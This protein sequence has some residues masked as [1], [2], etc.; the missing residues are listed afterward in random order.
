MPCSNC[1]RP[2]SR[3]VRPK[4]CDRGSC[5][6]IVSPWARHFTPAAHLLHPGVDTIQWLGCRARNIHCP[7]ASR[8]GLWASE[9]LCTTSVNKCRHWT[10]IFQLPCQYCNFYEEPA[11]TTSDIWKFCY[12][13]VWSKLGLLYSLMWYS[14]DPNFNSGQYPISLPIYLLTLPYL[15]ALAMAM[16]TCNLRDIRLYMINLITNRDQS[17][18]FNEWLIN[19]HTDMTGKWSILCQKLP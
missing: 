17:Q 19:V 6:Q 15:E 8:F 13:Y 11:Q 18:D 7:M 9:H 3:S 16:S 14:S 1:S 4:T 2:V 12:C 10:S 5:V